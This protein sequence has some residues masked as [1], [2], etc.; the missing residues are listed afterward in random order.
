[1]ATTVLDDQ[2]LIVEFSCAKTNIN[3]MFRDRV[4]ITVKFD[5]RIGPPT[6]DTIQD[7]IC[8]GQDIA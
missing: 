7:A 1:M 5:R 8:R 6:M 3:C 2:H 4:L